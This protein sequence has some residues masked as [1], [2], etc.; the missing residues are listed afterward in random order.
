M[1]QTGIIN[2]GLQSIRPINVFDSTTGET[3]P[4]EEAM[5]EVDSLIT[6]TQNLT[7][8]VFDEHYDQLMDDIQEYHSR[9][10]TYGRKLGYLDYFPELPKEIL[11]KSRIKELYLHKLISES[12]GYY[13]LK[14]TKPKKQGKHRMGYLINL[15]AVNSAM[16]YF[17]PRVLGSRSIKLRF[18]CWTRDMT[19]EFILPPHL[20]KRNIHKIT[21]PKIGRKGFSFTAQEKP[22]PTTNTLVAGIDLGKVRPFTMSI[23]D[24]SSSILAS[25]ENSKS[26]KKVMRKRDLL[27]QE[28]K[29]LGKKI[30]AYKKLGLDHTV[31]DENYRLIR[32][33]STRLG[34]DIA[35]RVGREIVDSALRY[36]V[37]ILHLED[38]RWVQGKKYGSRWNHGAQNTSIMQKA[39]RAGLKTKRVNPK[40]TSQ[41][42]HVCGTTLTHKLRKVRCSECQIVLD[43][44]LNAS[45][46]IA[47]DVNKNKRFPPTNEVTGVTCS[48]TNNT[49]L[50]EQGNEHKAQSV[51]KYTKSEVKT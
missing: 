4:V 29:C 12:A 51:K 48:D 7:Q 25:S 41:K 26:L 1:W 39:S 13:R 20:A 33:K 21:L 10:N 3:I 23:I 22:I 30:N 50:I 27:L 8:Q 17:E 47:K 45:L 24:S 44:D 49:V 43:R 32:N 9:P 19:F 11:V 6:F 5:Q 36:E 35:H 37:G 34:K 15:G 18:K 40:N 38:L 2:V 28:K 42:C 46:N 16:A 31:L 14:K